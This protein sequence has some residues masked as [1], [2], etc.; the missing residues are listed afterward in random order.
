MLVERQVLLQMRSI[1]IH[2]RL[3]E[4]T[5]DDVRPAN[6]DSRDNKKNEHCEIESDARAPNDAEWRLELRIISR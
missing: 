5:A 1:P 3:R 6:G 2:F 4:P